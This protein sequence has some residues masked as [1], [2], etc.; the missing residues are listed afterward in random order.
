MSDNKNC[1]G[2]LPVIITIL[3]LL[4]VL[5]FSIYYLNHNYIVKLVMKIPDSNAAYTQNVIKNSFIYSG[6]FLFVGFI[7]AMYAVY[8]I[9]KKFIKRLEK[10]SDVMQ[11]IDKGDLSVRAPEYKSGAQCG[12]S[13]TVNHMMEH[14]D[15]TISRFFFAST[16]I[17]GA[18]E[19]LLSM[20]KQIS[21]KVDNVNN[22]VA[23]VN[24]SAEE[25]ITRGENVLQ[26]CHA[27]S[28]SIADCNK[29][30]DEGKEIIM[31]NKESIE[32]ISEGINSIVEVVE[33]FKVQSE[34]I[35]QIVHDI[36]DIA[37]QTNLLALNAAIEA[38][39]AGD[40]GR[41]FAVV[42]DEVRKLASKTADSTHEIGKVIT[43]LQSRINDVNKSVQNSVSL[44]DKGIELSD[45]SVAAI[46]NIAKN[47]MHVS[48]QINGIV[49]SKEEEASALRDVTVN[50]SEINSQTGDILKAVDESASAGENLLGLANNITKLASGFKSERMKVFLPWTKDI[51][52]GIDIIDEQHKKLIDL[53]NKLYDS[54]K[55]N[56]GLEN[57]LPVYD[58][59]VEYTVYHFDFEEDFIAKSGYQEVPNHK[60]LH[61]K[62]K[63]EVAAQREKFVSGESVIGFNLLSFLEDWIRTHIMVADRK[64]ADYILSKKNN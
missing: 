58:E 24:A 62:L 59:L 41:G 23:G 8:F 21:S 29:D 6:A 51:E 40:H 2:F 20:Y 34:S 14:V 16:N 64:Y 50:T 1:K 43:E 3:S 49:T 31:E 57:L 61:E 9:N 48:E 60:V 44:V 54:M 52:L 10:L 25:L 13:I 35:G 63:A 46:D 22:S 33:G 19:H 7:I 18:S 26:M 42:A 4:G 11:S 12:I 56:A 27:S 15:S 39:R 5:A 37:E 30:A 53:I 32:A 28:S 17:V 45:K 55:N 47:V 38:A 36:N